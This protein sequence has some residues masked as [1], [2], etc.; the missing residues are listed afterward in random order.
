MQDLPEDQREVFLL[1]LHGDLDVPQI[2][3]LTGAP[4]ETVKSRLRYAQ[5][6]LRRRQAFAAGALQPGQAQ[7]ALG[8]EAGQVVVT[9]DQ[10]PALPL[11]RLAHFVG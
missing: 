6:K 7:G 11:Q 5:Q 10:V 8:T 2:A 3:A 9:Q 4:L 1:R